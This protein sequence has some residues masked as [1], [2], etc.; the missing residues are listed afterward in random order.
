MWP[1]NTPVLVRSSLHRFDQLKHLRQPPH[2]EDIGL[3]LDPEFSSSTTRAYPTMGVCRVKGVFFFG[4]IS[5]SKRER[6]DD[7]ELT[8]H[9]C[10]FIR[11]AFL[12]QSS[13]LTAN[14]GY[15][16]RDRLLFS[17]NCRHCNLMISAPVWELFFT[18]MKPCGLACQSC[19]RSLRG[20]HNVKPGF[21]KGSLPLLSLNYRLL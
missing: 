4:A 16:S 7:R 12:L 21:I 18:P 20:W 3:Q 2:S 17:C 15:A 9:Q 11:Q 6:N 1:K 8:H 14:A 13:F 10:R 19:K 5:T